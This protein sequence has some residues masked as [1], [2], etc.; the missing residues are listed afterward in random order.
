MTF[1]SGRVQFTSTDPDPSLLYSPFWNKT[2]TYNKFITNR[3]SS[4]GSKFGKQYKRYRVFLRLSIVFIVATLIRRTFSAQLSCVNVGKTWYSQINK[5]KCHLL[6]HTHIS[7]I[8]H[9]KYIK[10]TCC[11]N[12]ARLVTMH[13]NTYEDKIHKRDAISRNHIIYGK[14]VTDI[15]LYNRRKYN[16]KPSTCSVFPG[17][18]PVLVRCSAYAPLPVHQRIFHETRISQ[19]SATVQKNT[20]HTTRVLNTANW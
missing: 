9:S 19:N 5:Q 17:G 12:T 11:N 13:M 10:N 2:C 15:K 6:L 7:D 18:L 14:N 20:Q 8:W 3:N 16:M 4:A 1:G